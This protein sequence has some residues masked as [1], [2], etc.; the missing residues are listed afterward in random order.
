[1]K[2]NGYNRSRP[3]NDAG[4]KEFRQGTFGYQNEYER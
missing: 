4:V 1:M 2:Y 3:Y